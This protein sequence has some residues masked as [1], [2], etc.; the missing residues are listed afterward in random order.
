MFFENQEVNEM[1]HSKHLEELVEL[2]ASKCSGNYPNEDCP[3]DGNCNSCQLF[4]GET[5]GFSSPDGDIPEYEFSRY[6]H[7]RG[8]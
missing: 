8:E 4:M 7:N 1:T 2:S 5:I 6:S 3:Y